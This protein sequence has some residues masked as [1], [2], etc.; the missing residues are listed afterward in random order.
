M[1]LSHLLVVTVLPLVDK[2]FFLFGLML[3]LNGFHITTLTMSSCTCAHPWSQGLVKTGCWL[4]HRSLWLL[5]ARDVLRQLNINLRLLRLLWEH[6]TDWILQGRG[7]R[8]WRE[9][10]LF[11][12]WILA[13]KIIYVLLLCE[14]GMLIVGHQGWCVWEDRWDPRAFAFVDAHADGVLIGILRC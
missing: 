1:L 7:Y 8:P 9:Y 11:E 4:V 12:L 5:S 14:I 6:R 13:L 10:R 3:L 2:Q